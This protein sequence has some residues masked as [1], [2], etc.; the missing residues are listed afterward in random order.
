MPV[1]SAEALDSAEGRWAAVDAIDAHVQ[2]YFAHWEGVPALDYGAARAEYRERALRAE[3]RRA[4]SL[5]TKEFLARLENGHTGVSDAWLWRHHGARLPFV[6][7][8]L[9]GQWV[10]V[11]SADPRLSPGSVI[12]TIDGR[13]FEAFFRDRQRYVQASSEHWARRAFGSRPYLFPQAFELTLADEVIHHV[14]RS[15]PGTSASPDWTPH[16]WIAGDSIAYLR[17][18]TF[19]TSAVEEGALE[20]IGNEYRGA[21]AL[22]V[23]LRG[24][25]GGNT[26]WKLR[27]TLLQ[28]RDH[29]GDWIVIED[30]VRQPLLHRVLAPLVVRMYRPPRW[31]GDVVLLVDDGCFSACE[32]LVGS[33]RGARGVR[34]VGETTGGSTG[35][36]VPLQITEDFGIRVSARRVA[37]PDGTEFEGR[38]IKP[39]VHAVRTINDHRRGDDSA[40]AA[41]V[42]EA[43]RLLAAEGHENRSAGRVAE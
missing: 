22:V 12:R 30:N 7:R 27:K 13:P 25:G 24:N 33:L 29:A 14:E 40:L 9:Q 5:A 17:L 34:I 19:G 20:L 26:P 41:A 37:L 2:R 42:E 38:G 39:D 36:P 15:S 18:W 10:I 21:A 3:D 23:D 8:H 32:D 28:R 1:D 16:R 11:S 35:Q 43:R 31:T 6:L 4:F